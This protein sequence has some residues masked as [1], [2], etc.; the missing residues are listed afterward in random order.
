M[1]EVLV[2]L[3]RLL[4]PPA[5]G[6]HEGQHRWRWVVFVGLV[7]IATSLAIHISLA[8]GVFPQVFSGYALRSDEQAVQ[9]RLDVI[10]TLDLQHE[11]REKASQRCTETDPGRREELNRDIDRL[12]REYW[13]VNR[14]YY[15]I[16]GCAQL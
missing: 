6:D 16:P 15:Q 5:A 13:E 11:M 2:E 3:I 7:S 8:Q 1:R 4:I 12:Q 9:R 14:E 10:A